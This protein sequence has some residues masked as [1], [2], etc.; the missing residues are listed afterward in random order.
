[1]HNRLSDKRRS[2]VI[3]TGVAVLVL[4]GAGCGSGGGGGGNAG[5]G[6]P[7]PDG[8]AQGQ[9]DKQRQDSRG[10]RILRTITIRETSFDLSS[11]SVRREGDAL[12]VRVDRPG[13]YEFRAVNSSDI[14]HALEVEGH[15]VHKQTGDI[16]PGA[17]K[18]LNVTLPR[19]GEYMLYCPVANHEQLGMDGTVRVER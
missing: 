3:A 17:T 2:R 11:P 13:T 14:V 12:A 6:S 4:A 5:G 19:P 16:Q 15:G 8:S 9:A 10:G 1:M 7:Q 18:T